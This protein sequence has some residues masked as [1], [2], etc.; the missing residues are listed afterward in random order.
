MLVK[1][2]DAPD[3]LVTTLKELTGC[4][5]ASKAFKYAAHEYVIFSGRIRHLE[6]ENK[7]L[8][9]SLQ[10]QQ[11]VIDR[12]R[13]SAAALLDHVAQGDLLNG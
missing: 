3:D 1:I 8:R 5:T 4:W 9:Q 12:A 7:R 2:T 13:D 10:V 11:Q 6:D